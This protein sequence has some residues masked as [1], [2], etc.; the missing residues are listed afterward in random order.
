MWSLLMAPKVAG[1]WAASVVVAFACGYGTKAYWVSIEK[2]KQHGA[3]TTVTT[4]TT[5]AVTATDNLQ[6]S[7]LNARLAQA[8][9]TQ[10]QLLKMIQEARHANNAD[11]VN[12]RIPDGVRDAI[13]ADLAT[14]AR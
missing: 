14:G 9:V 2:A 7:A 10:Q 6:I 8:A 4:T 1:A 13:N 12:C 3:Q 11:G 5:A